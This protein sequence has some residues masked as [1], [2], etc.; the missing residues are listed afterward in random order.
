M[1]NMKM[2]STNK[3]VII[4][5]CRYPNCLLETDSQWSLNRHL[6]TH[7]GEKNFEC[8]ICNKAFVQKCSLTRHV[9][10]HSEET[11]FQCTQCE[12]P[13]KLK[14]YLVTHLKTCKKKAKKS[15]VEEKKKSEVEEKKDEVEENNYDLLNEQG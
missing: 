13:F 2:N 11:P 9:Q 6:K 3:P 4:L 10:T 14:E 12:K 5:H 7:T 15:K 1:T 8:P